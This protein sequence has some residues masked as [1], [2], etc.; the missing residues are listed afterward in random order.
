[1][2]IKKSEAKKTDKEIVDKQTKRENEQNLRRLRRQEE[3][4]R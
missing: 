2:R 4:M 1:M 3:P